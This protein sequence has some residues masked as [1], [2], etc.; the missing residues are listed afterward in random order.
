MV[1]SGMHK[2]ILVKKKGRNGGIR[3]V[4]EYFGRVDT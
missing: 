4:Q 2:N 1:V 3:D